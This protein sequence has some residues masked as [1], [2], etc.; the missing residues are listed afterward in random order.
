[1]LSRKILREDLLNLPFQAAAEATEEAVLNSLTMAHT[2]KGQDGKWY[3]SLADL[4]PELLRKERNDT[5]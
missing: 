2:V 5:I 4:L 1:M 3:V